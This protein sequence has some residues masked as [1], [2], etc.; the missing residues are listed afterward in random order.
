MNIGTSNSS[1]IELCNEVVTFIAFMAYSPLKFCNTNMFT[2]S[3]VLGWEMIRLYLSS[4]KLMFNDC[5]TKPWAYFMGL[6]CAFLVHDDAMTWKRNRRYWPFVRGIHRWPVDSHHKG[7]LTRALMVSFMLVLTNS[8][9]NTRVA[10][11]LRHH[12]A[13]VIMVMSLLWFSCRQSR[14]PGV[15]RDLID[16]YLEESERQKDKLDSTFTGTQSLTVP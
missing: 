10:V 8:W 11:D 6:Y 7:P 1:Q 5:T 14:T 4:S 2:E 16:A 3:A 15:V 12:A 13:R 9:T